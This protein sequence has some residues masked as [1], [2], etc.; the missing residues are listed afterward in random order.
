MLISYSAL[1]L[2]VQTDKG[3]TYVIRVSNSFSA[4]DH[5]HD[6]VDNDQPESWEYRYDL[7]VRTTISQASMT[8]EGDQVFLE[9]EIPGPLQYHENMWYI[10]LSLDISG[11]INYND[12]TFKLEINGVHAIA[13]DGAEIPFEGGTIVGFDMATFI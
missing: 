3:N 5:W 6:S 4:P 12:D 13:A 9:E 10:E 1:Y 11:V 2:Q 7:S 8:V